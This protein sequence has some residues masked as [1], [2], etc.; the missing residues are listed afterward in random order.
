MESLH[1]FCQCCCK[2]AVVVP[3]QYYCVICFEEGKVRPCCKT[4]YC[5]YDYSKNGC[6]PNCQN[7]SKIDKVTGTV[8]MVA[9]YSEHE[10]CRICLGPGLK[11]R[12]CGNYYCDECYCKSC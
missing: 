6:C 5:D 12:C 11:R 9:P 2:T 1:R 3:T 10:E 4:V 7:A 8:F